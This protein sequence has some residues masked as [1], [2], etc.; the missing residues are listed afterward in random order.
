MD[1][2]ARHADGRVDL[3]QVCANIDQPE[4]LAREIRALHDAASE[5][6]MARNILITLDRPPAIST[7]PGIT[8]A[9]ARDWLLED[10]KP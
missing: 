1:F 2:L 8:I 6:P 9:E 3:V 10:I 5:F 4:T 7:P